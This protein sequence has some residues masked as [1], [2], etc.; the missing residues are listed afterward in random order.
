MGVAR[1]ARTPA[2]SS[3]LAERA[4]PLP[5]PVPMPVHLETCAAQ[6]AIQSG[7]RGPAPLARLCAS[8]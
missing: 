6:V 4:V 2:G 7:R 3:Q 5:V 8:A 1:D